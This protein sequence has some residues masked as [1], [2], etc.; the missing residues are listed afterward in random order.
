MSSSITLGEARLIQEFCRE[1]ELEKIADRLVAGILDEVGDQ[2]EAIARLKL[3]AKIASDRWKRER[4]E[5]LSDLEDAWS[6][7][8]NE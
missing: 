5:W 3:D 1:T 2:S 8:K 6:K 4:T 7:K